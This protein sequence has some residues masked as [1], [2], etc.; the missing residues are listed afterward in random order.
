MEK[1]K[2]VIQKDLQEL[3]QEVMNMGGVDLEEE[4][5]KMETRLKQR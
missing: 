3:Q 5:L 1:Q 4:F 2:Q